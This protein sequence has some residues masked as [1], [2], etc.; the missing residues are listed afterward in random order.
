[1]SCLKWRKQRILFLNICQHLRARTAE[2]KA[3]ELLRRK[4]LRH[5]GRAQHFLLGRLLNGTSSMKRRSLMHKQINDIG[6]DAW[7]K[8]IAKSTPRRSVG[9]GVAPMRMFRLRKA[10]KRKTT[11]VPGL[12]D[13]G[14]GYDSN[15]SSPSR[16]IVQ[17][18]QRHQEVAV[19]RASRVT[20]NT[21]PASF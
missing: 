13:G 11:Q 15:R 9:L 21:L 17:R 12:P 7:S 1:M 4:R 16:K 3:D 5:A 19:V 2:K 14:A 18:C 8:K 10:R 20:F 6:A